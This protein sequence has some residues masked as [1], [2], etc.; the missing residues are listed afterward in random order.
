MGQHHKTLETVGNRL[1]EPWARAE[2]PVHVLGTA[3][4]VDRMVGCAEASGMSFLGE[5]RRR[6]RAINA[7]TVIAQEGAP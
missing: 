2:Y 5:A 1:C 7:T 6:R 4:A 3:Q